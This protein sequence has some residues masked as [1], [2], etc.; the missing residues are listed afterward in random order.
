MINTRGDSLKCC[1]QKRET[2]RDQKFKVFTESQ[3]EVQQQWYLDAYKHVQ[4]F[5]A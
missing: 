4:L 3:F 1:G 2:A 5:G